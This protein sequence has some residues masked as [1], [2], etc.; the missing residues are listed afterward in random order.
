MEH[1]DP[2]LETAFLRPDTPMLSDAIRQLEDNPDLFATR[3]RDMISGLRRVAKTLG[4]APEEVPADPKWLQP[5]LGKISAA[6]L[7]LNPKTWAN[8]LSNARAGLERCGILDRGPNRRITDLGPDW[9][10][11]WAQLVASGDLSLRAPLGRFVHFLSAL[12]V[13]PGEVT[14]QHARAYREAVALNAISKSPETAWRAAVN[15]WN[16]AGRRLPDWPQ[17]MLTLPRRQKVIKQAEAAFSASFIADLDRMVDRLTHPDPLAPDGRLKPL[18]PATVTQYRRQL[19][20]FASELLASGVAAAALPDLAAL[21]APSMAERG[22]RQMLLRNGNQ[23]SRGIAEMAGLLRNI[24]RSHCGL[25]DADLDGLVKL[26]A[27]VAMKPQSGLT[28]KNR[29]CLAAMQ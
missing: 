24:G 11:L 25:P 17:I 14:D 27:R 4:R 26:A 19:L 12:G 10:P 5:R 6:A 23:R 20:R 22:L 28:K 13:A 1:F 18:R 9:Q 2:R 15:G 8:V 21:C 29:S 16:L 3:T 7:G